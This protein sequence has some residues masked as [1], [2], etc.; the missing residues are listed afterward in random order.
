MLQKP[1]AWLINTVGSGKSRPGEAGR[2]TRGEPVA[3]GPAHPSDAPPPA[4]LG[5]AML[6]CSAFL[7]ELWSGQRALHAFGLL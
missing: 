4:P 2:S 5:M 6:G 3:A 1:L 7:M